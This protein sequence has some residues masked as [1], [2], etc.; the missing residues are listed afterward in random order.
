MW[1]KARDYSLIFKHMNQDRQ[2]IFTISIMCLFIYS[3][4][5]KYTFN[6]HN[7]PGTMVG[8]AYHKAQPFLNTALTHTHN[9]V[10]IS[11]FMT[12]YIFLTAH[13]Y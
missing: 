6:V 5:K 8:T 12:L 13:R 10:P 4:I 3:V 2:L 1:K 11:P 7:V 9:S